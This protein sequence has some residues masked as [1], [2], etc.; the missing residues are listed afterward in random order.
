MEEMYYKEYDEVSG[1]WSI[2]T[3]DG[4]ELCQVMEHEADILL[5]HLNRG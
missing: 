3:P 5:S 2:K 4:D 1:N